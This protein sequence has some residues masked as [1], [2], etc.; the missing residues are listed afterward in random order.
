MTLKRNTQNTYGGTEDERF[1]GSS[2]VDGE[3]RQ[4]VHQCQGQVLGRPAPAPPATTSPASPCPQHQ[5]RSTLG[6]EAH[7]QHAVGP[8][9]TSR[10]GMTRPIIC[11]LL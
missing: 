11:E 3:V 7:L 8:T 1:A 9:V 10:P 5:P 4:P 2:E 6:T